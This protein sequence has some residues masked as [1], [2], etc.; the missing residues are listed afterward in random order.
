MPKK[1]DQNQ[2]ELFAPVFPSAI[3]VKDQQDLMQYPFFSLSKRK[4]TTPIEFDDGRVQIEVIA[5]EKTGIASIFDAD[6]LIYVA[7]QLMEAHNKGL[8]TSPEIKV[9]KYDLIEF[10]GKATSGRG[11]Q[12]LRNALERL[13]ATSIKTTIRSDDGEIDMEGGFSWL[14][15][16][17]A[18]KKNGKPVAIRF[19]LAEWLYKGIVEQK[20]VLTLDRKYFRLESG[21]E[22]FLYRL[23]RKVAGKDRQLQMKMQTVRERSGSPEKPGKFKKA[24]ERII[25]KQSIPGYWLMLAKRTSTDDEYLCAVQKSRYKTF[26]EAYMSGISFVAMDRAVLMNKSR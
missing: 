2:L 11:Y 20:L 3:A 4:R 9:S 21:L 17:S 24:I 15:S 8:P 16:W 12:Q 19:R 22:R 5:P 13:Q 14:E 7:S 23:C 18:V 26:E 6:V 1:K 10:T 25:E